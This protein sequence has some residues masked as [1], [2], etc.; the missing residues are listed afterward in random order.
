MSGV[1]ALIP[2]VE[3]LRASHDALMGA[4]KYE[5][6]KMR[7]ANRAVPST[8]S[9]ISSA[10]RADEKSETSREDLALLFE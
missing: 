6:L 10:A 2:A 7:A 9:I 1:H 8:P 4:E 5:S 3:A